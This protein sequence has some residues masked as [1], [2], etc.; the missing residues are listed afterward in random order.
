[1]NEKE[2]IAKRISWS[3]Y[4]EITEDMVQEIKPYLNTRVFL[5]QDEELV[6]IAC[7]HEDGDIVFHRVFI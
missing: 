7:L 3:N 1:M 4:R 6:V 2:E 5:V